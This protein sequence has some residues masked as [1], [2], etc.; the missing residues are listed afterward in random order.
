MRMGWGTA[1]CGVVLGVA[2]GFVCGHV[3]AWTR[4]AARPDEPLPVLNELPPLAALPLSAASV[5]TKHNGPVFFPERM[6][7]PLPDL[8]EPE[9]VHADAVVETSGEFGAPLS[10]EPDELLHPDDAEPLSSGSQEALRTI[11]ET[12]LADLSEADR[13]VWLDVLNG[14]PLA[15]AVGIV[16]LWKKFGNGP[17]VLS[18][19]QTPDIPFSDEEALVPPPASPAPIPFSGGASTLPTRSRRT[20]LAQARE[21]VLINLLNTESFGYRRYEPIFGFGA[22]TALVQPGA[23]NNESRPTLQVVA[24]R[25]DQSPGA[26]VETPS[27]FDLAIEG[28]GF[29]VVSLPEQGTYYTRCGRFS[30]DDD[31]RL[32]LVT[33]RGPYRLTP[34]IVV[35]DDCTA[36][37]VVS[38]GE[39]RVVRDS[40]SPEVIGVLSLALFVD[41]AQLSPDSDALFVA[42]DRSGA[43]Q[44]GR[45]GDGQRGSLRQGALERSNSY[46]GEESQLLQQID[47]WLQLINR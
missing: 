26:I 31:G 37:Q 3:S 38:D 34:E 14:L 44:I 46:A 43:P 35:P 2:A 19:S 29:F 42:N 9:T 15:D 40:G 47:D 24:W 6:T 13:E 17:G 36:L 4:A 20:N 39:V 12:E 32:A 30:R 10:R 45:P 27:T 33:S 23:D 22:P 5:E 11:L 7:P 25:I 16:R 1:V 8:A 21:L 18:P 41:P 28:D